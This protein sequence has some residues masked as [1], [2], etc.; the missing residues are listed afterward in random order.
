MA[1]VVKDRVRETSSTAGTGALTLDGAVTGFQT[2]SVIGDGNTTYYT[3]VDAGT[4]AWEVGIGTYTASGTTLSRDTVLESSNSNTLVNFG[5]NLKDVFCTYP[6]ETSV[7]D[8][9]TNVIKVNSSDTALRITQLGTGNALV[10]E[11]SANP[12]S[13]PVVVDAS[14]KVVVGYT[15]ALSVT[16]V[17]GFS[18]TPSLQAQGLGGS[19]SAAYFGSWSN[20]DSQPSQV[21]F[22]KSKSGTVGANGVV[23]SGTDI[24][25]VVFSADDGSALIPA[26]SIL[27]EVDGTPGTNDM[28]GRLVFST[29]ADGASS[30]TEKM[31]ITNAGNVGIGTSSPTNQLEVYNATSSVLS[32]SSQ[33]TASL[34]VRRYSSN[35]SAPHVQTFK[36]RGTLASPTAVASGDSLGSVTFNGY[37]GTTTVNGARIEGIVDASSGA[38]DVPTRMVFS[39]TPDGTS[40]LAEAMRIHNSGNLA[41]GTTST[42]QSAPSGTLLVA[43][44]LRIGASNAGRDQVYVG[45]AGTMTATTGTL[46]FNFKSLLPTSNRACFVKLS[47]TLRANN[48][49]PS[50]SPVAEYWFQL[51]HTSAGAVTLNNPTTI[52]EYSFVYATHVAFANLGSGECTVTLTNPIALGQTPGYKVE[53]LDPSGVF[54]LDTVTAA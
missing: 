52:F 54:Y 25:A 5:S 29:T 23:A 31:R 43:T 18:R 47:V 46:V 9:K 26:A 27:G 51:H 2:F 40:T 53:I 50:N 13:T 3:I 11:D 12:D 28:P 45:T 17:G 6:A 33:G 8:G 10:V 30:P 22:G 14:G 19:L 39:V 44:G 16:D 34:S 21:I 4:G 48:A 7:S 24:G 38:G 15:S 35:T 20:S 36:Y 32:V 49:T 1:L 42:F 41:I 37:D